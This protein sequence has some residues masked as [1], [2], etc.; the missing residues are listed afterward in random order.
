MIHPNELIELIR[1]SFEGSV[2]VYTRGSCYKLYKI[3]KALYPSAIGYYNSDHV[4]TEID[5][6][7]Y[8]ITGEVLLTNHLNIDEHYS[9]EKLDTLGFDV[10]AVTGSCEN[11]RG[12]YIAYLIE[13]EKKLLLSQQLLND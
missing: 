5:G 13:K 2:L 11:C 9:H 3:L 4:I 12:K 7:F 8:D 10:L 1:N 6:K